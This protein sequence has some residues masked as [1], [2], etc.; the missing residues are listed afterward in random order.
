[1]RKGR[2]FS[3]KHEEKLYLES[4]LSY[5]GINETIGKQSE[6]TGRVFDRLVAPV[7]IRIPHRERPHVSASVFLPT[8]SILPSAIKKGLIYK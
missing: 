7:Y 6:D 2:V 1:M 3:G 4:M 8:T 5:S